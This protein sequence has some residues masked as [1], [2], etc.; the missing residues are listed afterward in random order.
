MSRRAASGPERTQKSSGSSRST[1]GAKIVEPDA[2]SRSEHSPP[3]P[4]RIEEWTGEPFVRRGAKLRHRSEGIHEV[5]EYDAQRGPITEASK[6]FIHCLYLSSNG[7]APNAHPTRIEATPNAG[8]RGRKLERRKD[9]ARV[10]HSKNGGRSGIMAQRH[11]AVGTDLPLPR[12]R[13]QF[14][15][16]RYVRNPVLSQLFVLILGDRIP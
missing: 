16:R 11:G 15:L 10:V 7:F 3:D 8:K 12:K 14:L 4:T 1:P 13:F 5:A 2:S 9:S 6:R